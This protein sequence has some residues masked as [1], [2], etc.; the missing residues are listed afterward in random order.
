MPFSIQLHLGAEA[1]VVFEGWLEGVFGNYVP[2]G[3]AFA[4]ASCSGVSGVIATNGPMVLSAQAQIAP[5]TVLTPGAYIAAGAA[6]GEDIPY[7]K[8]YCIFLPK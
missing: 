2:T 1:P 7:G 8:P 4:T 6:D 3:T 5:G